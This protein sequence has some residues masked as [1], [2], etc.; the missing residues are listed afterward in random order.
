MSDVADSRDPTS[1]AGLDLDDKVLVVG[2]IVDSTVEVQSVLE[3]LTLHR[4]RRA[5][6]A[7]RDFLALLLDNGDD[8]LRHQAT[9]LHEIRVQPDAHRVL[10]SAEHRY[11]AHPI[12][13][14]EFIH[15]IDHGEVRQ[16]Q[17]VEATVGRYNPDELEDRRR[18]LLGRDT[19]DLHLGGQG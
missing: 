12:E 9:G 1:G 18:L 3:V 2:R 14:L 4:R 16:E 6:L 10:A 5:N 19:M 11:V 17:A 7:G 15:D 8:I 13:A